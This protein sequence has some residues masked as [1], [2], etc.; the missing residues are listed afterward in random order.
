M[1]RVYSSFFPNYIHLNPYK[2]RPKCFSLFSLQAHGSYQ[3]ISGGEIAEAS[4][5][6]SW[7]YRLLIV[8]QYIIQNRYIYNI[9]NYTVLLRN[10]EL[11]LFAVNGHIPNLSNE[12][13]DCYLGS[14]LSTGS[15]HDFPD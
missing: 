1:H 13:V 15:S 12:R 3:A 10:A 8:I 9:Q 5:E 14:L 11:Y 6:M 4:G 2:C 7:V